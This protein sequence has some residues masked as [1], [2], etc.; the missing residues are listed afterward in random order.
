MF[1]VPTEADCLPRGRPA[2]ACCARDYLG[3][4]VVVLEV[5]DPVNY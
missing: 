4:D 5:D 3:L 2:L 1:G